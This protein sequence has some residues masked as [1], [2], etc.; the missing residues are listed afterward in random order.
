MKKNIILASGSHIRSTLLRSSGV[1]FDIKKH[2]IDEDK[3]KKILIRN[4]I[5]TKE[6][7]MTLAKKKG[8]SV[9]KV[10]KN[11]FI[12]GCDQALVVKN[13]IFSKAKNS[14][15]LKQQL[16]M[17]NG[18]SHK[19]YSSCAV[20]YQEEIVWSYT[21]ET[22]LLM[23]ELSQREISTYVDKNWESVKNSV[24]GY[25]IEST[26]KRLFKAIHGDYFSA[27]GLPVIELLDFLI[28]KKA[29][30]VV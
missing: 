25:L 4:N 13:I 11:S 21:A 28:S 2:K 22:V 16:L 7:P 20:L 26:G 5:E 30:S 1:V 15:D 24:G 19:L 27:L 3:E 10:Y 8:M 14:K 29:V 6:I 17:L 23:R 12:I 9:S 18:K